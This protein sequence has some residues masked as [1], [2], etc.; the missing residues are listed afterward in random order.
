MA[1]QLRGAERH[2]LL[3]LLE[4]EIKS[5]L[6]SHPLGGVDT[7]QRYQSA[8]VKEVGVGLP[9]SRE[10]RSACR[11]LDKAHSIWMK[12]RRGCLQRLLTLRLLCWYIEFQNLRPGHLR[13]PQRR[14]RRTLS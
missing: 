9:S 8:E 2:R 10:R 14:R 12:L 6:G 11:E 1:V 4:V 13:R 3:R 5:F 7:L